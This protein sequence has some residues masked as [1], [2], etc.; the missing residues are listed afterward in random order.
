MNIQ[1]MSFLSSVEEFLPYGF[2]CSQTR[3]VLIHIAQCTLK[4]ES[5]AVKP[6]NH[7]INYFSVIIICPRVPSLFKYSHGLSAYLDTTSGDSVPSADDDDE[8]RRVTR[9]TEAIGVNFHSRILCN[10]KT[11]KMSLTSCCLHAITV[12]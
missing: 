4:R 2:S 8:A 7:G 1:Y 5:R 6:N 12:P 9:C 10:I 11:H 3:Q